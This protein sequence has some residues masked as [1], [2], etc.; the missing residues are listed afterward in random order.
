M[1]ILKILITLHVRF[2]HPYELEIEKFTVPEEVL[3]SV[4]PVVSILKIL[5][6]KRSHYSRNIEFYSFINKIIT[7]KIQ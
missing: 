6:P 5:N 2:S 4:D 3:Q 1:I 7:G